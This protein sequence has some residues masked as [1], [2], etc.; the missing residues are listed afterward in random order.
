MLPLARSRWSPRPGTRL[1]SAR[2]SPARSRHRSSVRTAVAGKGWT[3]RLAAAG[4]S[5]LPSGRAA[6]RASRPPHARPPVPGAAP[7]PYARRPA[8]AQHAPSTRPGAWR[9][10]RAAASGRPLWR[11]VARR[12]PWPPARPRRGGRVARGA[13]RAHLLLLAVPARPRPL[14]AAAWRCG[15]G[16]GVRVVPPLGKGRD[17]AEEPAG[18]GRGAIGCPCPGPRPRLASWRIFGIQGRIPFRSTGSRHAPRLGAGP[19]GGHTGATPRERREWPVMPANPGLRCRVVGTPPWTVRAA[20]GL[21]GTGA[22]RR[23]QGPRGPASRPRAPLALHRPRGL[24]QRRQCRA[25]TCWPRGKR[26]YRGRPA[27]CTAYLP[28]RLVGEA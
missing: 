20:S 26:T 2:A 6:P 23:D 4:R 27:R 28:V 13:G 24:G 3:P 12:A 21:T 18:S 16:Q 5:A 17:G 9:Q 25:T 11:A 19:S 7:A 22:E 8:R 14:S 10:D 1:R 15:A